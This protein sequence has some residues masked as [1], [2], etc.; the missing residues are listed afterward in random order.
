VGDN[1]VEASR[2]RRAE[3]SAKFIHPLK[4]ESVVRGAFPNWSKEGSASCRTFAHVE[5]NFSRIC[6]DI[7]ECLENQRG[8]ERGVRGHSGFE[9]KQRPP[10]ELFSCAFDGLTTPRI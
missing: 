8:V 7:N 4:W 5:T 3:R 10:R 1:A 6:S 2:V 9:R